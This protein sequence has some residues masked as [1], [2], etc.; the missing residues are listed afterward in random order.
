[1]NHFTD[2]FIK[3]IK[4]ERQFK[5]EREELLEQLNKSKFILVDL[6]KKENLKIIITIKKE[7]NIVNYLDYING[8]QKLEELYQIKKDLALTEEQKQELKVLREKL[9][10]VKVILDKLLIRDNYY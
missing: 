1:M 4:E 7:V 2:N 3:K 10:K 8:H 5:N 6:M 9:D